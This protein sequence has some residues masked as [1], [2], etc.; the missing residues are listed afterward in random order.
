[1][2]VGLAAGVELTRELEDEAVEIGL[3]SSM[4]AG[5][6]DGEIEMVSVTGSELAVNVDEAS[7]R[8]VSPPDAKVEVGEADAFMA[9]AFFSAGLVMTG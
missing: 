4:D 7:G 6:E 9:R 3:G 1:M 5:V 2:P 8:E